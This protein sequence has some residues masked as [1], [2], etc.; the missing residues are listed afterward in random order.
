MNTATSFSK[1]RRKSLVTGK[2]TNMERLKLLTNT[3]ANR[4]KNYIYIYIYIYM[5]AIYPRNTNMKGWHRFSS[6]KNPKPSRY[7]LTEYQYLNSRLLLYQMSYKMWFVCEDHLTTMI[8]HLVDLSDH[9]WLQ[10]Q[11]GGGPRDAVEDLSNI[12][13]LFIKIR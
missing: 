9:R 1:R 8:E 5:Y 6:R 2:Q 10:K 11:E 7:V 4:R 12:S 3:I 13:V